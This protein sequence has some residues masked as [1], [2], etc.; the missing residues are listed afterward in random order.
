MAA[1]ADEAMT[2]GFLA[3]AFCSRGIVVSNLVLHM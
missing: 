2:D 1:M 3:S